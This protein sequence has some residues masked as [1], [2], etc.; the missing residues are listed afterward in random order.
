MAAMERDYVY[1]QIADRE[2]PRTWAEEGAT[3]AWQR[4]K[5]KAE[6]VLKT[7]RPDY[8]GD[9]ARRKIKDQFNILLD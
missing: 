3:D 1:P 2:Q 9:V 7:H 6:K 5:A 8:L 4:A